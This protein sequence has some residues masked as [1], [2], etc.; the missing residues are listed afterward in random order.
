MMIT[1]RTTTIVLVVL[2]ILAA[3]CAFRS[4][5]TL[6]TRSVETPIPARFASISAAGSAAGNPPREG[7]LALLDE[8]PCTATVLEIGRD[9]QTTRFVAAACGTHVQVVGE[10]TT[11]A[12]ENKTHHI[13]SVVGNCPI[14]VMPASS[15]PGNLK[16]WWNA[17]RNNPD[18]VPRPTTSFGDAETSLSELKWPFDALVVN[19]ADD[20]CEIELAKDLSALMAFDTIVILHRKPDAAAKD[21]LARRLSDLGFRVSKSNDNGASFKKP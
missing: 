7:V 13:K 9:A 20:G 2:A 12:P 17:S 4:P 6:A 3:V 21:H 14:R 11:P 19:C 15:S 5:E 8:I 18:A 10:G 1:R 16:S